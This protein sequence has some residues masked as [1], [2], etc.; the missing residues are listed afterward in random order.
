MPPRHLFMEDR[1]QACTTGRRAELIPEPP[2]SLEFSRDCWRSPELHSEWEQ[3]IQAR[4]NHDALYQT[5]KFFEHLR[6][7]G[8]LDDLSLLAVWTAN[9]SLAGVVPLR[10]ARW[11]LSFDL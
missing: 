7:T 6:A 3:L 8:V 10:V 9:Q 1:L 11:P 5:P 4:D 2:Y